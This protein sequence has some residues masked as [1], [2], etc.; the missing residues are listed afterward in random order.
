M[1]AVGDTQSSA[2]SKQDGRS[3]ADSTPRAENESVMIPGS[4][5]GMTTV[6]IDCISSHLSLSCLPV[7]LPGLLSTPLQNSERYGSTMNASASPPDSTD[8]PQC[9]AVN[10]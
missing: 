4:A 3:L 1:Q 2:Y 9:K 6:V 7:A 8:H 5:V 10:R